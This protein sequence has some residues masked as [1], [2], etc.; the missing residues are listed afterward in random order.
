MLLLLRFWL[1]MY[2]VK[3]FK[4]CWYFNWCLTLKGEHLILCL[5]PLASVKPFVTFHHPKHC[6]CY[7]CMRKNSKQRL[8]FTHKLLKPSFSTMLKGSSSIIIISTKALLVTSQSSKAKVA[9]PLIERIAFLTTRSFSDRFIQWAPSQMAFQ[10]HSS[11]CSCI[12]S[13]SLLTIFTLRSTKTLQQP[14][15]KDSIPQIQIAFLYLSL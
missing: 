7:C 12:I 14:Y 11:V 2:A 3:Y 8:R 15:Q 6:S 4:F 1:F 13:I 5:S 10:S 9:H